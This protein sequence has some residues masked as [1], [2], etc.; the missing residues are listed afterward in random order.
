MP[1]DIRIPYSFLNHRKRRRLRKLLGDR[2]DSYLIDLWLTTALSGKW[3]GVLK[4]MKEEDI[5]EEVGYEGD[6]AEFCKALVEAGF[7]KQNG[8]G[9]YFIHDWAEHQ[10]YIYKTPNR[11]ERGRLAGKA[12]AESRRKE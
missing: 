12:S 9:V 7:I 8:S 6:S 5:A 11:I 4:G 10:D 3:D 2:S 1:H